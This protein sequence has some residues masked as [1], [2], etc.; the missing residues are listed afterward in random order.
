MKKENKEVISV[1]E[2]LEINPIVVIITFIILTFV[3][4]VMLVFA[5]KLH[6]QSI[7]QCV[8]SGYSE[9]YCKSQI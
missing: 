7:N 8:S 4:V 9:M 6:N 2:E 5:N 3:L 1:F